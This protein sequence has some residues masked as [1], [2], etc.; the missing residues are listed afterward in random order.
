MFGRFMERKNDCT[1]SSLLKRQMGALE[2]L[3]WAGKEQGTMARIVYCWST[4]NIRSQGVTQPNGLHLYLRYHFW[5]DLDLYYGCKPILHVIQHAKKWC[6]INYFFLLFLQKLFHPL[7]CT[8]SQFL[9][10]C[11]PPD[12]KMLA[13]FHLREL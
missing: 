6:T 9:S 5:V 11:T 8:F 4:Q 1:I 12:S 3:S 2:I 7:H 13:H 10:T